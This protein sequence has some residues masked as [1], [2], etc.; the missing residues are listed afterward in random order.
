[1]SYCGAFISLRLNVTFRKWNRYY[2][3]MQ[4]TVCYFRVGYYSFPFLW[5]VFGTVW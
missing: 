4:M 1:M 5:Q 3:F 2:V